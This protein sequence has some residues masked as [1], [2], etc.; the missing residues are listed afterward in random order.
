MKRRALK[1]MVLR[2]VIVMLA[3]PGRAE[4]AQHPAAVRSRA[5]SA[6]CTG[7]WLSEEEM[8]DHNVDGTP[9]V[10]GVDLNGRPYGRC[11]AWEDDP[12]H[13]DAVHACG[14]NS[15]G[16]SPDPCAEA[17]AQASNAFCTVCLV[18]VEGCTRHAR[19]AMRGSRPTRCHARFHRLMSSRRARR[20]RRREA[21]MH[22]RITCWWL[23]L[24]G[25][26]SG[27]G[28]SGTP[29]SEARR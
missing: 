20:W 15:L 22:R 2:V 14:P 4:P 24:S 29:S 11:A 21:G 7:E 1:P 12:W 6:R 8:P 26:A 18:V 5:S 17:G 3:K 25:A 27:S 19:H 9:M 13:T 28:T 10:N 23:T 16:M